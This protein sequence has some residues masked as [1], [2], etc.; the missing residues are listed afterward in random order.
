MQKDADVFFQTEIV[1]RARLFAP[2][3]VKRPSFC[4]VCASLF[5]KMTMMMEDVPKLLQHQIERRNA[6][7]GHRF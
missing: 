1:P 2:D 4:P 5:Y 3:S 6:D 7:Q